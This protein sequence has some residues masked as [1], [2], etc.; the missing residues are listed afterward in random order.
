MSEVIVTRALTEKTSIAR[1]A[2]YRFMSRCFSHPDVE[3]I[4]IFDSTALKEFLQCWSDLGLEH[5]AN[6]DTAINWLSKWSNHETALLELDKE[7]THLFISAYPRVVAP[8]YSSLYLSS[9]KLIWGNSTADVAKMYEAAGL[10]MSEGYHDVPDHISAELEFA[11]YLIAE[12]LKSDEQGSP[13]S[14]QLLALEK[15]LLT[16]HLYKWAP[17]FFNRV[18]EYSMMTFYGM[19]AELANRFIEWDIA[20]INR[21]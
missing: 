11:S 17:D 14:E 21:N 7:Y 2:V 20:Y 1:A 10:T 12:Q 6:V 5:P 18:V 16:E 8:P 3:L 9:E 15:R 19:M 13:A 4:Q